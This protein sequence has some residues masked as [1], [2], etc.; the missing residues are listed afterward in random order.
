MAILPY[1]PGIKAAKAVGKRIAKKKSGTK[2]GSGYYGSTSEKNA[3]GMFRKDKKQMDRAE[4][5]GYTREHT[6]AYRIKS[7]PGFL[8]RK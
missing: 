4:R 5:K 7:A 2:K 6:R 1:K 8:G 3:R